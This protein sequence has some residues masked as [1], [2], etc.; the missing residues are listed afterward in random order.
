MAIPFLLSKIVPTFMFY[1][2]DFD[3]ELA[4]KSI[5][6]ILESLY[7]LIRLKYN[8][9]LNTV[10]KRPTEITFFRMAE[11]FLLHNNPLQFGACLTTSC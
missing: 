8:I 1:L 5:F 10:E 3:R 6:K 4:R 9:L 11:L 2:F 7:I